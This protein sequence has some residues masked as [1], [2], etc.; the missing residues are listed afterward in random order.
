MYGDKLIRRK[1]IKKKK[2]NVRNKW[3]TWP[4]MWLNRSVVTINATLQL[5]DIYIDRDVCTKCYGA[6]IWNEIN[7]FINIVFLLICE[8]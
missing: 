6:H 7:A 8:Y 2:E 3:I 5:L 4:L 1:I